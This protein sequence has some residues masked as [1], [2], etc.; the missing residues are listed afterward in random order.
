MHYYTEPIKREPNRRGRPRLVSVLGH[1]PGAVGSGFDGDGTPPKRGEEAGRC[2]LWEF[3]EALPDP[4]P[5]GVAKVT[6]TA[7]DQA[8]ADRE[9]AKPVP[10]PEVVPDPNEFPLTPAERKSVR[11]MLRNHVV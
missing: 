9:A 3:A 1:L 5:D 10:E 8:I 7:F 2:R 4:L 11:E 6:S